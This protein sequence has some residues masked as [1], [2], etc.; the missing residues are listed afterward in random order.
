MGPLTICENSEEGSRRGTIAGIGGA[1]RRHRVG[2]CGA[3]RDR[4][5]TGRDLCFPIGDRPGFTQA[6][7][8][9]GIGV[10]R[11]S[12]V[13]RV[14]SRR[15][16][17]LP[18]PRR[19]LYPQ[20]KGTPKSGGRDFGSA[21]RFGPGPRRI[22]RVIEIGC[23]IP[24]YRYPT[25]AAPAM[26]SITG[27]RRFFFPQGSSMPLCIGRAQILPGCRAGLRGRRHDPQPGQDRG[28]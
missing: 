16:I 13:K 12:G 17:G 7:H 28:T 26:R 3:R 5:A 25:P 1:L 8:G 4:W 10:L 11:I 6:R 19:Y 15:W 22:L 2:V 23:K 24:G 9:E 21:E 20:A 27:A 14:R 18:G